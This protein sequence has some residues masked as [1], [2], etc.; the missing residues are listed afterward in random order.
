MGANLNLTTITSGEID[1]TAAGN[2]DINATDSLTATGGDN[3]QIN[4]LANDA[5]DKTFTIQ[6]QNVGTG[7][8]DLLL[9]SDDEIDLTAAAVDINTTGAVT[10]NAAAA[11]NFT[12]DSAGLTLNT[13]TSGT[14]E[15]NS[16]DDLNMYADNGITLETDA[17][18]LYIHTASSGS[19]WINSAQGIDI[20]AT[21]GILID[22]DLT[23]S[24]DGN[25]NSNFTTDDGDLTLSTTTNGTVKITAADEITFT[26]IGAAG[27]EFSQGGDRT[28]DKTG[29]GEVLNGAT[30]LVGAINRLANAIEVSSD[31]VVELPIEN[32]V[33]IS[34]GDVVAASSTT[35]RVTQGNANGDTNG[36]FVG[37]C[38]TGGTGD[39]G[40][41]VNC[42][43]VTAG[44]VT[45]SGATFTAQNALYMPD[46]TGR[47]TSTATSGS[48]DLVYR[49]GYA[50]SATQYVLLPGEGT[51]IA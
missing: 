18:T 51:V 44:L 8:G 28:F 30:S 14:L 26:D 4:M 46:G 31:V 36:A 13:T 39:V 48:G 19:I 45:D 25:G 27:Y 35:G 29:A 20:D 15:I 9:S 24:I 50:V 17:D 34:A 1:I 40:G 11:S 12:V 42:E 7:A 3:S 10:I 5:G 23:I 6:A 43:F 49:V 32:G 41:T 2:V 38:V 37:I 33:T 21:E 47:P 22:S 16:I